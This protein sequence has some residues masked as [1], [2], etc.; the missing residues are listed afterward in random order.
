MG[1]GQL[2]AIIIITGYHKSCPST[3]ILGLDIC[4]SLQQHLDHVECPLSQA[5]IRAVDPDPSSWAWVPACSSIST[6]LEC[7]LSQ[8]N[9]RAVDPPQ[10][11]LGCLLQPA[12]ASRPR[13]DVH[14]H[15]LT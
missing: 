10:P 12:A 1:R 5:N 3:M 2:R 6:T 13:W 9:V 14:Y 7:P 8:A 15:R 11:R 4:S